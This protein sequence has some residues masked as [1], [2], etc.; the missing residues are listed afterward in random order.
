MFGHPKFGVEVSENNGTLTLSLHGVIEST[1]ADAFEAEM[2]SACSKSK[3]LIA[4]FA[5]VNFIS[6]AGLRVLL[7]SQKKMIAEKGKMTLINL[8]QGVREILEMTGF[9]T[10]LN[11]A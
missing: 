7:S 3:N 10:M 9:I 1:T 2:A 5:N 11:I 4:D 8:Q 6:S